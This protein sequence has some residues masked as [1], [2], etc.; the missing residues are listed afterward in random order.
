MNTS[1]PERAWSF[2]AVTPA[3]DWQVV[4]AAGGA[5]P[6]AREAMAR[7]YEIYL[8]VAHTFISRRR[9]NPDDSKELTQQ[10]F[11]GL[12]NRQDLSKVVPGGRFRS[13]F[14]T[15]LKNFLRVDGDRKTCA[16]RDYRKEDCFE[17]MCSE[18]R[19][20]N[21]ARDAVDPEWEFGNAW[22]LTLLERVRGLLAEEE[23]RAGKAAQFAALRHFL[24]GAMMYDAEYGTLE[25]SFQASPATL[26]TRV[27]KLRARYH[28]L[29]EAEIARTVETPDQIASELRFLYAALETPVA[30]EILPPAPTPRRK[31]GST[32]V[33]ETLVDGPG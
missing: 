26:K 6:A 12:L 24:P 5:G 14:F 22:A 21:E 28:K 11:V 4:L 16:K 33:K 13:W 29:L 27:C 3:T 2:C 10:F 9:H 25:A 8:P 32:L 15:A 7:L 23:E 18:E 19:Q 20:R 1:K 31:E 30:A 17:G